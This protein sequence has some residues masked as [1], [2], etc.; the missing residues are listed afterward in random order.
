MGDQQEVYTEFKEQL[1][2]DS[3]GWY[4][5]GLPWRGN[6]PPLGRLSTLVRKLK[7]QQIIECYDKVISEQIDEGIVERTTGPAKGR[8]FYIPHKSVVR[9]ASEST[10]LRVV[11]DTS[12]RAN[13]GAPSLNE[14][15]N[16]GPPF[17]NQLWAVLVR[18]R[19]HP[20]ASR[21]T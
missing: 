6:H 10:K 5:T 20:V 1:R 13:K 16:P 19:F 8:E 12:A 2:R 4:E 9:E 21:G 3:T 18:F 14:C 7:N 15:L 17:Q 11:Y